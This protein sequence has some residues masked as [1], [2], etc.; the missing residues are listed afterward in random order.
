MEE[1]AKRAESDRVWHAQVAV[2]RGGTFFDR[3]TVDAR[4][5]DEKFVG[6]MTAYLLSKGLHDDKDHDDRLMIIKRL[7]VDLYPYGRRLA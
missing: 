3:D 1:V 6:R 7:I 5:E 4:M 2:R